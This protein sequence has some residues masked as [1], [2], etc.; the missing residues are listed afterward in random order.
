MEPKPPPE[1]ELKGKYKR[2]QRDDPL[3]TPPDNNKKIALPPLN[4]DNIKTNI[5]NLL[6]DQFDTRNVL[7]GEFADFGIPTIQKKDGL[8]IKSFIGIQE[9]EIS[10]PIQKYIHEL[11]YILDNTPP[12]DAKYQKRQRR[13][14][15]LNLCNN[16]PKFN[17]YFEKMCHY[18][19]GG[20]GDGI[21]PFYKNQ[22]YILTCA[23]G[24]IITIFAQVLYFLCILNITPPNSELFKLFTLEPDLTMAYVNEKDQEDFKFLLTELIMDSDGYKPF[25]DMDF[26]LSI[27]KSDNYNA[28]INEFTQVEL[29]PDDAAYDDFAVAR[30]KLT[31]FYTK[32]MLDEIKSIKAKLGTPMIQ[33]L[34]DCD[35]GNGITQLFPQIANNNMIL[36]QLKKLNP[37]LDRTVLEF[38]STEVIDWN[39]NAAAAAAIKTILYDNKNKNVINCNK[40]VINCIKNICKN[41]KKKDKIAKSTSLVV[42]SIIYTWAKNININISTKNANTNQIHKLIVLSD[43]LHTVSS[44]SN[45][46]LQINSPLTPNDPNKYKQAF[47]YFTN[48]TTISESEIFHLCSQIMNNIL[49]NPELKTKE[50][51]EIFRQLNYKENIKYITTNITNTEL[52]IDNVYKPGNYIR[53]ITPSNINS[54]LVKRSMEPMKKSYIAIKSNESHNEKRLAIDETTQIDNIIIK[55]NMI[56]NNPF[57]KNNNITVPELKFNENSDFAINMTAIDTWV[58]KINNILNIKPHPDQP[59]TIIDVINSVSYTPLKDDAHIK[60]IVEDYMSVTNETAN[61]ISLK[62]KDEPK[63]VITPLPSQ[64]DDY[65]SQPEYEGSSELNI[66]GLVSEYIVKHN[67]AADSFNE[68]YKGKSNPES[69][70]YKN[71]TNIR[72]LIGPIRAFN[73]IYNKLINKQYTE[74]IQNT[75][76]DERS[77]VHANIIFNLINIKIG[78]NIDDDDADDNDADEEKPDEV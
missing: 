77:N 22:L 21:V 8:G 47:D 74:N 73:K 60:N 44:S 57:F 1:Q 46:I 75:N 67:T 62:N 39:N 11:K 32:P 15:F 52:D 2:D 58:E 13:L 51:G 72:N 7:G 54:G 50:I 59:Y 28:W 20:N 63:D 25:S 16:I 56:I 35:Y 76:N 24:N 9:Y 10:Q 23:G 26:K 38:L 41:L 55:V 49:W 27:A 14:A 4:D 31:Q 3:P 65:S 40:N 43:Y 64:S 69:L 30:V 36:V 29:S 42:E 12:T 37:P 66:Y 33:Q 70:L 68:I 18:L 17:S 78:D 6:Y 45:Q 48:L 19:N 71:I 53:F 34:K 61:G 5:C